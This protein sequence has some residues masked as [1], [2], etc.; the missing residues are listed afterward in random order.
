MLIVSLI[1]IFVVIGIVVWI[2][3]IRRNVATLIRRLNFVPDLGAMYLIERFGKPITGSTAMV[4]PEE[5]DKQLIDNLEWS[6]SGEDPTKSSFTTNT[7]LPF[8]L[9]E[10][11]KKFGSVTIEGAAQGAFIGMDAIQNLMEID[12]HVYTAMGTLAGEQLVTIGD[13]SKHL[14]S[15]ESAEIGES[16]PPAAVAKLMGHLSEPIVAENLRKLGYQV[17]LPDVSNQEGYDLILNGEY[18]VN[19]KT[20]ADSG[21]LASHFEKYPDIPVIVPSDMHGIPDD[22][23]YLNAEDSIDRLEEA[24]DTGREGIVLV[25]SELSHTSMVEYTEAVSDGLLGNVDMVAGGIPLIT[26]ALSGFREIRLLKAQKTD[27][28]YATKNLGADVLGTGV[29]GGTGVF[30]GAGIGTIIAPG[31]GTTIGG[32]I[33]GLMGSIAGRGIS[34]IIKG[35]DLKRAL[36]EYNDAF[37]E[38]KQKIR[39]LQEDAHQR[40]RSSVQDQTEK[41]AQFAKTCKNELEQRYSDLVH[42]RRNICRINS[43]KALELLKSVLTELRD[44]RLLLETIPLWKRF[45][46]SRDLRHSLRELISQYDQRIQDLESE[47]VRIS[48]GPSQK[49]LT[50]ERAVQVLQ[51]MLYTEEGFY[52][53]K[54]ILGSFEEQRKDIEYNLQE[55][56]TNQREKLIGHRHQCMKDLSGIIKNLN[57]AVGKEIGVCRR[58]L[59]I[60][61][62]KVKTEQ[63]RLGQ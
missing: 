45:I 34:N 54:Q 55:F 2:S 40:F 42:R 39:S 63:G 52:H 30:M 48:E 61:E 12:G 56:I 38:K 15:W 59:D 41:L 44:S 26:V 57:E 4:D 29:G 17:E 60:L 16:L 51:A 3:G 50:G 14:T 23:I 11:P 32:I 6:V 47:A 5:Y 8:P 24:V 25:D 49:E 21:S 9:S 13:L 43:D 33:G 1:G 46:L 18:F 35:I 36:R 20:V 7:T 31:I 27:L 58:E 53:V 37:E 28:H 19:V 62:Q 10:G 22:A